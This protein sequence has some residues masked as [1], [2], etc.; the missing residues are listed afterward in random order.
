MA[1][2]F[3]ISFGGRRV[4]NEKR[5]EIG[6]TITFGQVLNTFLGKNFGGGGNILIWIER[7]R[8]KEQAMD[9]CILFTWIRILFSI[10]FQKAP[11]SAH[12]A[13]K[14]ACIFWIFLFVLPTLLLF[15][16]LTYC[17]NS[18]V[19]NFLDLILTSNFLVK[20]CGA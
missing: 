10:S 15:L 5:K 19:E 1:F 3:K 8:L 12:F 4:S 9:V 11:K 18:L 6:E 2:T 13:W 17:I 16:C 20:N 14:A 7:E